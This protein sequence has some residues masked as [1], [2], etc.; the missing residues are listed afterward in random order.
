M[1]IMNT[2]VISYDLQGDPS[3]YKALIQGIHDQSIG[4]P[5]NYL[6]NFWIIRTNQTGEQVARKLL[7]FLDSN[8]KLLVVPALPS[9][10]CYC[11][12]NFPPEALRWLG[13]L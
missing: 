10:R 3:N 1:S 8:D 2:F 4:N 6:K 11:T 5:W 12:D 7:G 13:G 9:S